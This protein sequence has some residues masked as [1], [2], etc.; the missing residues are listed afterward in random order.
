[1][2][3]YI[4]IGVGGFFGAILRYYI[5]SIQIWGY[6][7]NF[8]LNTLIINI[9]GS[10]ILAFTLTIAFEV[11]EFHPDIRH[12]IAAG[13]LGAF[14]TFSTMCKE[15]ASLFSNGASQTAILY[16]A[17]SVILGLSAVYSGSFSARLIGSKFFPNKN[18]P[19][20]VLDFERDVE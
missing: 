12:G 1:M 13:F 6:H 16:I 14:T 15:S 19:E 7:A 17:I 9:A 5:K 4:F 18:M 11:W 10:F 2:K 8:P 3:K 20:N